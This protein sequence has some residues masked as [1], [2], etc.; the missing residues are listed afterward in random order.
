MI[1][2][3]KCFKSIALLFI[4]MALWSCN[5]DDIVVADD[6]YARFT[7]TINQ[8]TGTVTFINT[9]TNASTY[10]WDF[11]DGTSSS[12]INPVK[13]YSTGGS[14]VVVLQVS[15]DNGATAR[16]EDTLQIDE[17][18]DGGLLI[19]GD[20]ENGVHP[21]IQGVDEN[22]PAPVVS[23][24]GNTYYQ[25]NISNPNSNQPFLV[26]L[27][28]KVEI[29]QGMTYLLTFDA[30]SDRNRTI[31]A[32]IGLSGG[33]FANNSQTVAITDTQQ[34]YQLTL[35]ASNF[36][37]TDAR[38]LFDSNGEAGLVTIDNVSLTQE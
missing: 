22:N 15:N 16:F 25:V 33:T 12:V 17:L 38:V 5:E 18:F 28:Q 34:Q 29:T 27:S 23:V 30:W 7:Q 3:L 26:N 37:A 31:I 9:S 35:I 24:A 36:G 11:G 14:Y 32:G 4:S 19:N 8:R 10:A 21:W 1:K 6:L 13:T 20:F 2:T